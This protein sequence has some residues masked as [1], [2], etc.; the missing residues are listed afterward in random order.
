MKKFYVTTPI[1]YVNDEPHIGHS[2]TTVLA[3]ALSRYHRLFGDE[4]FF[5]TGADEHGQKVQKAAESN[6]ITPQEQCGITVPRYI[7]LWKKLNITNSDFIRT[8]EERH[9]KVVQK[10]LSE[11]YSKGLIYKS[12]Y[13]GRYCVPC[14]RFF[15]EKNLAD[16]MLCPECKRPTEELVESNYFFRMSQYQDW[17]IVYINSHPKFIQPDFRRNETLGFLKKKLEDLCISRPKKRLSWGIELPF[18]SEYVCY[19]WFDALINYIS[20]IGCSADSAKFAKWWPASCHLIGKDILTTHTVYWP[21]MLKAIGISMPEMIFAHG[22]WLSGSDKMSKSLGNAVNPMGMA[23]KYGVDAFRYFLLSEMV[24]GQDASFTEDSFVSK[25]NSDLANDLGNLLSRVQK[26]I[27]KNCSAKIPKHGE[28]SPAEESLKKT[29]LEAVEA[30]IS[31]VEEMR[32]DKGISSV[33]SAVRSVN[34]YFEISAPWKLAKE[35]NQERLA[36]ILYSGAEALR[37]LSGLLYPVMPEKM[38]ELRSA[39]GITNEQISLEELREWGVLAPDSEVTDTPPL[40]PRIE[41]GEASDK[42]T[43][44]VRPVDIAIEQNLISID[45]F[46]SVKLRTARVVEAEK[47]KGADK[48]LKLQIEIGGEKRQIVAGIALFYSPEEIVGKTIVVVSNLK[49]A[50]IRGI[51]SN[52]MLLAAKADGKLK[53]I[54]VDGDMPSGA[55]V[56]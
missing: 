53:L 48:L 32:L 12:E 14:E 36:T 21:I 34:K 56:G 31:S 15:M 40:F 37:I 52:G 24:L 38:R 17:L 44:S 30:I 8:T 46:A 1:Y 27:I 23:D 54:T 25:Y 55:D 10:I 4:V 18:D 51:E 39:L 20:A 6:K 13:S 16:G 3:D 42:K 22:W 43:E 19:V 29:C 35:G 33:V 26:M 49:P 2:Y 45:D 7:E 41:K 28:F 9:K 11:L 50:K 47:I 5:L